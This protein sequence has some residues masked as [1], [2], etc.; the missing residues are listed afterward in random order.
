MADLD[1]DLSNCQGCDDQFSAADFNQ[2]GT[3]ITKV[4]RLTLHCLSKFRICYVFANFADPAVMSHTCHGNNN[5]CQFQI[6][7]SDAIITKADLVG[8]NLPILLTQPIVWSSFIVLLALSVSQVKD[9]CPKC[10]K[11]VRAVV[12]QN[13][14]AGVRAWFHG[15]MLGHI[16]FIS[17]TSPQLA[18]W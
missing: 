6:S 9:H 16:F 13:K 5:F 17:T 14:D 10:S 8:L 4:L 1:L 11:K 7:D 12:R 15:L 2:K 18:D 3:C